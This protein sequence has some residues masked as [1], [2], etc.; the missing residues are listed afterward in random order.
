MILLTQK[1]TDANPALARWLSGAGLTL[2]GNPAAA[3]CRILD[4]T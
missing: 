4:A 3:R 1:T 2:T